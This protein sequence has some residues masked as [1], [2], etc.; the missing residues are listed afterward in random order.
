MSVVLVTESA[1]AHSATN[2]DIIIADVFFSNLMEAFIL[3]FDYF[4]KR[5]REVMCAKNN[6]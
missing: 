6:K 1:S 2:I 3:H 4:D 5:K